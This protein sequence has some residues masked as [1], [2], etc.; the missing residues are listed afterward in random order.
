MTEADR[1]FRKSVVVVCLVAGPLLIAIGQAV[2]SGI[3]ED[4]QAAMLASIAAEDIRYYAGSMISVVG[5]FLTPIAILGLVH[6][7]RVRKRA[8]GTVAGVIVLIGAFGMPGAWLAGTLI[9]YMASQQADRA[10]MAALLGDLES[11][12]AV[13]MFV[14][15]ISF[16]LGILLL[17]I[18]LFVAR[19]VPRWTAVLLGVSV[20]ALFAGEGDV[21]SVVASVV[22][23][24][25]W[26][27]VA[28]SIHRRTPDQWAAGELPDS[29]PSATTQAPPQTPAAAA[30]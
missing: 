21:G 28:W 7:V 20:V 1:R 15:W 9:D 16:M 25:A 26:S 24:A 30:P 12:A 29:R 22:I 10:A 13:P 19:T 11:G 8:I 23:V 4:D 3:H 2:T 18:G 27:S 5:A 17:A 6:L 14:V